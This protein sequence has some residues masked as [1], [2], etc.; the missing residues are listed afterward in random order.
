[1]STPA[2]P[3]SGGR[4]WVF[5]ADVDTDQLVPGAQMKLP[6][7]E[8]AR[9][10]LE[11]VDPN[12]AARVAPGDFVIAGDNF[13]LGS[14]R[15]QAAE[16]LRH[17]GVAAVIAK[18][19]GGIFYRNAVNLGLLVIRCG[20]IGRIRAQDRLAVAADAGL[21]HNLTRGETYACEPVPGH[22]ME[23]IRDGGLLP[24]LEG[25]TLVPAGEMVGTPEILA[26][27]GRHAEDSET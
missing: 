1:M 13:G 11:A 7:A 20:D 15:E 8:A 5:G 9:H 16:V 6:I 21:V 14:S 3:E 19:F 27:G 2:M 26:A 18:S 12:F 4:A 23:I 22:L 25:K 10:C 17:L 24:H